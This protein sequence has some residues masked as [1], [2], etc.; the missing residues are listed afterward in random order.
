MSDLNNGWVVAAGVCAILHMC[1][2]LLGRLVRKMQ[3]QKR[4]TDRE[5]ELAARLAKV[6]LEHEFGFV[7]SGAFCYGLA[8]HRSN[9]A[10]AYQGYLIVINEKTGEPMVVYAKAYE[11]PDYA[12]LFARPVDEFCERFRTYYGDADERNRTRSNLAKFV[13]GGISNEE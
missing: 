10:A 8:A 7:R 13:D 6:Q 9:L 4:K 2:A 11:A 1:L 5:L 12:L 3:K